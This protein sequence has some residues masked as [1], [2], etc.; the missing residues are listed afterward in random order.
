MPKVQTTKEELIVKSIEVFSKNGYYH[1]SFS[2]LAKACDIEK[3]HFYYY[4]KDKR[5]L[6]D[7]CLFFFSQKIQKNVFDISIDETMKPSKRIRKMLD[8]VWNLYTE[9]EYG[10]LFGNTLLETVGKEPY[11]EKTIRDFFERWKNALC[12]LY[13]KTQDKAG[14]EE[15]AFDDIEKLQGSIMLMRLY[16]D[17]SFLQRAI[18]QISAR[19]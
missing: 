5:D 16:K 2:D 7:Q 9:N 18:N 14:L 4:F 11:F 19:V 1:T 8:Y 6:M 10:C 3:S 12:H 13:A 17:K 15:I